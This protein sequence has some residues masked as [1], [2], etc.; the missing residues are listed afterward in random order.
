MEEEYDS[1]SKPKIWGGQ[2]GV[3][4]LRVLVNFAPRSQGDLPE[5]HEFYAPLWGGP[6]RE[7]NG[8]IDRR[9]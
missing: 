4:F 5:I 6:L 2:G 1:L 9:E 3:G 7:A 8:V